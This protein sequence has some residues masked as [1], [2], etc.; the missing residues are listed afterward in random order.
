MSKWIEGGNLQFQAQDL[1][2]EF[3]LSKGFSGGFLLH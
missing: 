2:Y 3:K 1:E